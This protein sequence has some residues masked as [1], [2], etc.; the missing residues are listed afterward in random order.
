MLASSI[1]ERTEQLGKEAVQSSEDVAAA[2]RS[3]PAQP[4]RSLS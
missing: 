3:P 2:T 4:R 1:A